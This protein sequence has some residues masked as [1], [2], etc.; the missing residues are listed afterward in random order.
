MSD[1]IF[2]CRWCAATVTASDAQIGHIVSCPECHKRN[3]VRKCSLEIE[4][5]HC[6]SPIKV[7][8]KF[9]GRSIVCS[10]CKNEIEIEIDD[11]P[12]GENEKW[13]EDNDEEFSF[14]CPFCSCEISAPV[15]YVGE[16]SDCPDCGKSVQVPAVPKKSES[17]LSLKTPIARATSHPRPQQTGNVQSFGDLDFCPRCGKGN[18]PGCVLCTDCGIRLPTGVRE[19]S[20][21]DAGGGRRG[22]RRQTVPRPRQSSSLGWIILIGLIVGVVVGYR[23]Y[24][25]RRHGSSSQSEDNGKETTDEAVLDERDRLWAR[26]T[27]H[28]LRR[29]P[30]YVTWSEEDYAYFVH[31]AKEELGLGRRIEEFLSDFWLY[32]SYQGGGHYGITSLTGRSQSK[33][34][35]LDKCKLYAAFQRTKLTSG[36]AALPFR[37]TYIAALPRVFSAMKDLGWGKDEE[38]AHREKK[39]VERKEKL[40]VKK[41]EAER[42]KAEQERQIELAQRREE[43]RQRQYEEMLAYHIRNFPSPVGRSLVLTMAN[44]N[45]ME[46]TIVAADDKTVQIRKGKAIITLD[47]NQLSE[48]SRRECFVSDYVEYYMN[49]RSTHDAVR[50]TQYQRNSTYRKPSRYSDNTSSS[51]KSTSGFKRSGRDVRQIGEASREVKRLGE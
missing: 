31:A 5:P 14:T 47:R 38:D 19:T 42:S 17:R 45:R 6:S 18:P 44:G 30:V 48:E 29:V 20:W 4:C 28:A 11:E 41:A 2:K 35:L 50:S 51:S 12:E 13:P 36:N 26:E 23:E 24:R 34:E 16:I 8:R 27:V 49:P 32:E 40:A 21:A 33:Q 43:E 39:K 1:I 22:E 15:C 7:S 46:G 9:F 25:S 3:A 10:E 37:A